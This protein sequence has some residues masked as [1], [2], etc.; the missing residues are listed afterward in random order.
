MST[1]NSI[2]PTRL[3]GWFRC[4]LGTWSFDG[5]STASLENFDGLAG[6][7]HFRVSLVRKAWKNILTLPSKANGELKPPVPCPSGFGP[8]NALA[9]ARP[10]SLYSFS[11]STSFCRSSGPI[12]PSACCISTSCILSDR[13]FFCSSSAV[14]SLDVSCNL[15][16]VSAICASSARFAW[17]GDEEG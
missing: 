6:R 7:C 8:K 11:I 9:L 4:F 15:L 5:E 13:R 14:P 17:E 1:A 16:S 2:S 10:T 3:E 12:S